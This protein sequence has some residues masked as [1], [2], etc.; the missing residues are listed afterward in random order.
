[1][2]EWRLSATAIAL[3]SVL[4]LGLSP[5]ASAAS[6]TSN[7][8]GAK[9]AGAGKPASAASSASVSALRGKPA[10]T[11]HASAAGYGQRSNAYAPRSNAYGARN[12]N[13]SYGAFAP[14]GKHGLRGGRQAYARWG[15]G[16]MSCVPYARAATGM[17]VAGNAWQWWENAAGQYARGYVPEPGSILA[18]RSNGRM[19]MGHVAVVNH[20]VNARQVVI[21]HANWPTSGGGRGGVARNVTVVDVS[22]RNDW[23]AVRVEL[24]RSGDYGSVYPTHG[25][26][27]DRPDTGIV[28]T[29][30]RSPTP[31]L[32]LNPA[33]RDLRSGSYR[34]RQAY[35]EVAEAPSERSTLVLPQVNNWQLTPQGLNYG[36]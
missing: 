15:G 2:R 27:Y 36:N 5:V 33:P 10:F 30:T 19:P 1:M 7:K 34:G 21:D 35:E 16:G 6:A 14:R 11:G 26:I 9:S 29:A 3:G 28:R 24:G 8:H 31:Q 32:A 22:D 17:T 20:V 13:V 4:I 12:V 23:S 25:F 18:F